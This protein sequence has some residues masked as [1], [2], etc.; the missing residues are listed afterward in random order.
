MKSNLVKYVF[1]FLSILF[2]SILF[3]C[4]TVENIE[5]PTDSEKTTEKVEIVVDREKFLE[6]VNQ[7]I[8]TKQIKQA[9]SMYENLPKA[10]KKSFKNDFE[11]ELIRIKLLDLD[12]QSD[13]AISACE[14]LKSSNPKN[15]SLDKLCYSIKKK[16]F[17]RSLQTALETKSQEEVLI[18]FDEIDSELSKDFGIGILKASLLLDAKRINEAEL[19]C[20][21]LDKI[22]PDSVEVMEIRLAITELKNDKKTKNQ[23]LK[24]I[25]AKDPYNVNANVELAQS[26][27]IK[28]NYNQAKSYY[29]KALRKE[30]YN[31]DALFGCGQMDYYLKNDDSAK[32][33]F[34]TLLEINPRNASAYAYLGKIYYANDKYKLAL[35]NI[36][37]ALEI[38]PNNY[39]YNMDYGTYNRYSGKFEAAEKAWTKAIEINPNYFLAYAYRAG[40]RDEQNKLAEAL[41]DYKKVVELNPKYYYA[42]ENIGILALHEE[43]WED[44]GKAFF[45]CRKY[46]QENISYPLMVT[47]CYYKLGD[48][49]KAKEYSNSILR[50][51][52]DKNSIDYKM[53]RAFHDE[54][55]YQNLPQQVAMLKNVNQRGKMYYYLALLFDLFGGTE[56]AREF[57]SKVVG[58]NSPMFFEYRLA[59]WATK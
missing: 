51:M 7:L 1:L 55:G 58:L 41:E 2:S 22:K 49:I 21:E 35:D 16:K 42:Y 12:E 34:N 19:A 53:L 48:K 27:A 18:L 3:S 11:L 38:E 36:E 59:E 32:K 57:Y 40:I 43:K 33:I 6:E 56:A 14:E 26:S 28:K 29:L 45:E 23:Q 30:P 5:T 46:N 54:N 39:D 8:K 13:E 50:K 31:E 44:A 4:E 52:G 37:K 10:E 9:L 20:D 15:E 25:L 47:Y 17:M 24:K